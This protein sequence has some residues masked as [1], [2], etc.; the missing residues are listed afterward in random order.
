M[1]DFA[2]RWLKTIA[3]PSGLGI[4][5][6]NRPERAAE[7]VSESKVAAVTSYIANQAEHDRKFSFEDEL[8]QLMERHRTAFDERYIWD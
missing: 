8:R 6:R 7:S 1:S 3:R 5:Q 2:T 4:G